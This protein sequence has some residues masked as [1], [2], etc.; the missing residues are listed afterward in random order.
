MSLLWK[1]VSLSIQEELALSK[2]NIDVILESGETVQCK[3]IERMGFNHDVGAYSF[4]V[5]YS[6][7]EFMAVGRNGIYKKWSAKDRIAPMFA[8]R[9][10]SNTC[11]W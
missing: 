2:K 1:A 7:K 11:L 5:E 3:V 6:G 9:P 10:R 4:W 8:A